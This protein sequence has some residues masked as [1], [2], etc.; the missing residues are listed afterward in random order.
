MRSSSTAFPVACLTEADRGPSAVPTGRQ[1]SFSTVQ[2]RTGKTGSLVPCSSSCVWTPLAGK[3]FRENRRRAGAGVG[4]TDR[5]AGTDEGL[6][7]HHAWR[8]DLTRACRRSKIGARYSIIIPEI[9]EG[10]ARRA[11]PFYFCLPPGEGGPG[12]RSNGGIRTA[13]RAGT[14]TSLPDGPASWLGP[15]A[16]GRKV[17]AYGPGN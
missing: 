2:R 13:P 15:P 9:Q 17:A 16:T 5:L 3:E 8:A 1:G 6:S 11:A 12:R 4:Q 7:A 14:V 10:R